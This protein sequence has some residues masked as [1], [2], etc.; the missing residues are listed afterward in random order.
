MGVGA[1]RPPHI[2]AKCLPHSVWQDHLLPMLDVRDAARL[3]I[4]CTP[5]RALVRD[6]L[7]EVRE[8]E[9]GRKGEGRGGEFCPAAGRYDS[10]EV[11]DHDLV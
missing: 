5:L 2:L 3:S 11:D 8:C 7:A 4:A 6:C 10:F 9:D 1:E